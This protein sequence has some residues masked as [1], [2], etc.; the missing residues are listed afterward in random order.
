MTKTTKT[1]T[2]QKSPDKNPTLTLKNSDTKQQQPQH[3]P[4]TIQKQKQKTVNPNG[5]S[6]Y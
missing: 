1:T 2:P 5:F 3:S 4:I 6:I